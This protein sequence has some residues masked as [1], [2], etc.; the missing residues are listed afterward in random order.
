M[1]MH[2]SSKTR[3]AKKLLRLLQMWGIDHLAI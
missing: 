1:I 3:A 2:D